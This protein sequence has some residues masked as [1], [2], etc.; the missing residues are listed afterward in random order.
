MSE[1][2][3]VVLAWHHQVPETKREIYALVLMAYKATIKKEP[4]PKLL[5]IRY[6]HLHPHL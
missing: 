4:D 6:V 1:S 2:I 3:I 5:F